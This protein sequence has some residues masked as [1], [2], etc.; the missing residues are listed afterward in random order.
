MH[1]FEDKQHLA[2]AVLVANNARA[3]ERV[4]AAGRRGRGLAALTAAVEALLPLDAERRLEWHVWVAFWSGADAV[5]LNGARRVLGTILAEPFAQAIAD[6]ELPE[7]LDVAYEC[8]RL[9]T[10][11]AGLGL[12]AGA[13]PAATARR[14]A[15]RMVEDHLTSLASLAPADA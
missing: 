4:A 11:A 7:H 9:M 10:L 2:E 5:R 14:F 15:R 1:Y 6:G 8:E 13:G 3:G 12:M